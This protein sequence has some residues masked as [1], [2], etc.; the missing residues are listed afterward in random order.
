M[1][2]VPW[3]QLWAGAALLG[4]HL[5]GRGATP[6]P[7]WVTVPLPG[8]GGGGL[9]STESI[10]IPRRGGQTGNPEEVWDGV[11]R[12]QAADEPRGS[13]EE[14]HVKSERLTAEALGISILADTPGSLEGNTE[15]PGTA[16]S[17]P[18]L[19]S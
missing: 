13:V 17:E 16:S 6:E 19:P 3:T 15:G 11:S 10:R 8:V 12:L 9:A 1:T 18:L 5:Q 2:H 14:E 7:L 4:R